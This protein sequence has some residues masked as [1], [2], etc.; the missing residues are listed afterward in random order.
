MVIHGYDIAR[1]L[2]RTIE[3]PATSLVVVAETCRATTLFLHSKRRS[4]GLTLNASDMEWSAGS[5]PEVAG[6]LASI[7]LA[8]TGRAAA[9]DD[10]C[11]DGLDTL[12][13]RL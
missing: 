5:G 3:V 7:I 9:L 2:R 13:S 6:P 4:A 11:G 10:L 12:R 8:I 1:P